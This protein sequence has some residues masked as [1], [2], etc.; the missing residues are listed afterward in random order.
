MRLLPH[1]GFFC[2]VLA[3]PIAAATAVDTLDTLMLASPAISQT[4]VA[5]SYDGDLWIAERDGPSVRRLTTHVGSELSPVFSP[6]GKLLAFSAQYDG[7]VDV[8]VIPV[9]GGVPRRLTWHPGP[10]AVLS[11]TPDGSSI[12]FRSSRASFVRAYSQL[13]TV[14]VSGGFEAA[15]PIPCAHKASYSPDGTR[16]AYTPLAD[17]FD[18]WK[19][20]RGGTVSRIWLFTFADKS[21]VEIPQPKG[22]CNDTDPMWM[23][24]DTVFFRSDRNGEFNLY[25]YDVKRKS[26]KQLTHHDDFPVVTAAAGGGAIVYEQGARL[27]VFDPASSTTQPMKLGVASE[28]LE[29]RP[30]Y[31]KGSDYIRNVHVSPSGSRAVVEYR[32]EI[33][34]VPAAKGDP[35]NVTLSPGTHERSPAWAP[36][37]KSIAY[38]SDESGEYELHVRRV[39]TDHAVKKY[40]LPGSGFY[41]D[42]RWSPDSKA[43]TYGDNSLSYYWIDLES[44][45]SKKFAQQPLYGP[46]PVRT[47]EC[48]WSPDSRWIVYTLNSNTY[49]RKL[50]LYSLDKQKSYGITDGLSDVAEPLFDAGGKYLYF[51]ASTDAGPVRQWFAMSNADMRMSRNI[52]LAVLRK[53]LP[54]PLAKE[55]DEEEL[56]K[57]PVPAEQPK[58]DGSEDAAAKPPQLPERK[59]DKLSDDSAIDIEGLD[60]RI[61]AFDLPARN[62]SNLQ[63]GGAGEF[64]FIE[65]ASDETRG[66]GGTLK[67]FSLQKR[68]AES[69]LDNVAAYWLTADRKKL[70][71]RSGST[72]GIVAASAPAAPGQGRLNTDAIEVLIDPRAE[73]TQIFH[74]AWR[75]NRDF[76]YATN[77]HGV[78]WRA[79]R[80]KYAR[81]LPHLATRSDLNRVIQWM[82]SEL[83]VGH[84]YVGG[85][86]RLHSPK[87]VEV[88]L[89]GADYEI[90]GNRYRFKKVFGGLNWTPTLRAPL[91]EPGVNVVADEYLLEVNGRPLE[92]PT[93]LYSA[94]ENTAGKLVQLRVGPHPDGKDSRLVT[95]VPLANEDALRN[96]DWVEGNIRKVHKA[97]NG[98]VAY[99]YVPNTTTLGHTY[100]KRYFYPQAN[101]DAII[102]DERFNGGGQ[103]ADYYIDLLRRPFIAYWATR[104]GEDQKSPLASIQGPKVMLIDETAGSGGDLLPW[105]FKKFKLGPLVGKRTWGGL[106]GVLGFPVLM[107]GGM[108]S[109]PDLAIW[110]EDGWVV[111]NVGVPPDVEVEQWP[112]EVLAGR[113]PQL[114]KAIEIVLQQLKKNPPAKPQRPPFPVRARPGQS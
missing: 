36:N 85:G 6:D 33:V 5:F 55:S 14:P 8:Y 35:C 100:F 75:I 73:W 66:A 108:V 21:V 86:D 106:V 57:E 97:T 114:E 98:R 41:S 80:E 32:G 89:L 101:L 27:H 94:F 48:Q 26:V 53:E 81:F 83:S 46:D 17:R 15:L 90:A 47:N 16:L 19:N 51:L 84:H 72:F 40:K 58:A 111:E 49:I 20:Y 39:D 77:Y 24:Q 76:F 61:V 113:D 62:Y 56:A 42:P 2:L 110:T 93:N 74:E 1:L 69:V 107:D 3:G 87:S 31:V 13:Y 109:A 70:L 11:F 43:I 45:V 102:V 28:L 63:P 29:A 96:R 92:P 68:S 112:A 64:F 71:Y 67:R 60:Q 38:F 104:H 25:S 95:V 34:T 65:P 22:R 7:N 23:S 79:M 82:C 99:V 9:E 52:Y 37:G 103:I 18:Q 54:S 50:Y 91:T 10:D 4:H 105:M 12:L 78:D 30:R 44:G 88:G 59:E